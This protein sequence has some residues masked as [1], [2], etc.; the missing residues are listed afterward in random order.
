MD[1]SK[2]YIMI[3]GWMISE[4]NLSGNN[5]LMYGLVYGF[6][7]DGNSVFKGS[8]NYVCKWLNCSKP[9]AIKSLNYLVEKGFIEKESKML[10]GIKF[11]SYNVTLPVVK[12]LNSG[13]KE[14]L[15][16]GK[17]VLPDGS[18]ETLP[19]NILL[20]NTNDNKIY[21]AFAKLKLSNEDFEKLLSLGYSKKQIDDILDSIENYKLNKNYTSLFLTAKKW[22]QREAPSSQKSFDDDDQPRLKSAI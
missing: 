4:L 1:I 11:N 22:L 15:T 21:R 3:Q 6:C 5:L 17:E 16:G 9:T 7:Q 18:K 10:N 8:L 20:D 2:N 14:S 13:S 19:N 12:N